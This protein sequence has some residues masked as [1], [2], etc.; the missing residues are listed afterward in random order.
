MDKS[1]AMRELRDQACKIVYTRIYDQD[2][3]ETLMLLFGLLEDARNL[4]Y[5]E[6]AAILLDRAEN[7]QEDPKRGV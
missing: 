4:G 1:R 5:F 6:C 3:N 2:R 7:M